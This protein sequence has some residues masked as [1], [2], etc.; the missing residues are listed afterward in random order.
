MA[1]ESE[2]VLKEEIRE[3]LA[4]TP[5]E[6]REER[7]QKSG[8]MAQIYARFRQRLEEASGPAVAHLVLQEHRLARAE[9]ERRL[10]KGETF[11]LGVLL[12]VAR[13]LSTSTVSGKGDSRL[14]K[15]IADGI[16]RYTPIAQQEEVV[17]VFGEYAGSQL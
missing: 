14:Y 17:T 9:F 13:P 6:S 15:R 1:L 7:L 10:D 4:L 12:E 16:A 8:E 3:I 2:L 5:P 11:P